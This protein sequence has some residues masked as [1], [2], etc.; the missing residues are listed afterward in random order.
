[1]K[2]RET[3]IGRER[4]QAVRPLLQAYVVADDR[5]QKGVD[6]QAHGHSGRIRQSPRFGNCLAA[7]CQCLV[8]KA[9][10]KEDDP[11]SRLCCQ[12]RVV[13]GLT[14]ERVMGVRIVKREHRFKV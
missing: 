10:T 4:N 5:Q 11:Q 3:L 1:M 13:S 6:P 2:E 7:L 12:L 14:H 8:G 9:E